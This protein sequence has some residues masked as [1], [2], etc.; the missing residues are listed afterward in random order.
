MGNYDNPIAGGF[1][2]GAAEAINTAAAFGEHIAENKV[3]TKQMQLEAEREIREI[4]GVKYFWNKNHNQWELFEQQ[5]PEDDPFPNSIELFTL[6]GFIGYINAN[7]EGLLS[8]NDKAIVYVAN[9]KEV[10]LLS[11]PTEHQ[12]DRNTIAQTC[13]HA[14]KIMFDQYLDTDTFNTML[15]STFH[16]TEARDS[17]FTLVKSMTK[18]QSATV[19]DDG[20]SQNITIME[21]VATASNVQFK[22]P[23]PLKPMRTFTEIDQPESN[24]TLRVNRD[25]EVTLIEADGGAWK[26]VAVARI[27]AYLREHITS[28]YVT[29]LA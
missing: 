14:P 21:G 18:N 27:A 6:D 22:N 28:P 3:A 25:A 17:V 5:I 15:L 26:N 7:P 20:V 4:D 13:A 2:T 23:V 8:E 12:K 19:N 1:F 9:E 16:Q 10:L 11:A 24:F 29:I